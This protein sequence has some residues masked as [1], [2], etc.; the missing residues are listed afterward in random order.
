MKNLAV[1][2]SLL[3]AGSA[4]AVNRPRGCGY[5]HLNTKL[6]FQTVEEKTGTYLDKVDFARL[7]A[8]CP[9]TREQLMALD[10][11]TAAQQIKLMNQEELDQLYARITPGPVPNGPF[12]GLIAIPKDSSFKRLQAALDHA[13]DNL[14]ADGT[15][16][17]NGPLKGMSQ[18]QIETTLGE[19]LWK[20]K[21]FYRDEMILRNRITFGDELR[22]LMMGLFGPLAGTGAYGALKALGKDEVKIFPA[23]LF[24]GQ[25][26]ADSR[27]EA[28]IIDYA[29]NDYA[30][31][32]GGKP[33]PINGYINW[34]DHLVGRKGLAV[35]DE[36]R[37][38][39]PGLYLG[40]AYMNGVFVLNFVLYQDKDQLKEPDNVTE[41]CWPGEQANYAVKAR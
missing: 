37:M 33:K 35:R 18:K 10:P 13:M 38:V 25:S 11:A 27:R 36:I 5:T 20:G 2:G 9:L 7:E 26:L 22:V 21:I 30:G 19:A 14:R 28:I 4:F 17:A 15:I 3:V 6:P 8:E 29:Y 39:R 34:L 31:R 24:C 40:R 12:N 1:I 32:E 23:K 16:P 41:S